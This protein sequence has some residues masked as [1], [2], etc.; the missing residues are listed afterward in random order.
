MTVSPGTLSIKI[1]CNKC[2]T[3]FDQ[4]SDIRTLIESLKT[5]FI[6]RVGTLEQEIRDVNKKIENLNNLNNFHSSKMT[7]A[8]VSESVERI[9]RGKNII[10]CGVPV[11][12]GSEQELKRADADA[13]DAVLRAVDS[14]AVPRQIIRLGRTSSGERPPL[15]KVVLGDEMEARD[16]LRKKGRILKYPELRSVKITDDKTPF[17]LKHLGELREEMQRRSAA[18]ECDLTIKYVRGSPEI[19]KSTIPKKYF[20]DFV[21]G[22]FCIRTWLP[23]WQ[24]L[25]ISY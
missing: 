7:E 23:F 2:A 15:M 13:V 24:N 11:V 16:V 9:R 25:M 3:K 20:M 17:Q 12:E 14:T 8:A 19:V 10:L 22:V 4:L 6:S 18:G 1:V 5:D 21:T